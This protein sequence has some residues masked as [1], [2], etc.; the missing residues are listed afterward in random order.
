MALLHFYTVFYK[1]ISFRYI[2]IYD[3]FLS[4]RLFSLFSL[5]THVSELGGSCRIDSDCKHVTLAICDATKKCACPSWQKP[6]S[7]TQCRDKGKICDFCLCVCVCFFFSRP[8][9]LNSQTNY[10][11]ICIVL[12]SYLFKCKIFSIWTYLL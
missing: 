11:Y 1:L 2:T 8:K 7:T 5:N 10:I 3:L 6:L 9:L 12:V 4:F